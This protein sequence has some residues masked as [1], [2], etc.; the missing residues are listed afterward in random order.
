MRRQNQ[1]MRRRLP[2][3]TRHRLPSS[4]VRHQSPLR[5]VM[6]TTGEPGN[7]ANATSGAKVNGAATNGVSMSG[8][9]VMVGAAIE[10]TSVGTTSEKIN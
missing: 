7:G 3:S 1:R 5:T 8:A 4:M 9:S 2:W 6:T 10:T